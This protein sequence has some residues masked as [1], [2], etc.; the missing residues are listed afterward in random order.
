MGGGY[1]LAELFAP[2]TR[3]TFNSGS[4][5]TQPVAY[6]EHNPRPVTLGMVVVAAGA[7]WI[8]WSVVFALIALSVDPTSLGMKL[9]RLLIAGSFLELVVAVWSHIIVRRRSECCAGIYTGMGICIGIVIA[10]VS[11][12]PSVL[13]L[14]QKRRKQITL[15]RREN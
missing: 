13:L 6:E 5:S 12:G 8:A 10:L 9:H 3:D 4:I 2:S 15:P 14:Y 1:A 11:F 7:V